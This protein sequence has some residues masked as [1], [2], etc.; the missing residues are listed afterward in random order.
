MNKKVKLTLLQNKRMRR[1]IAIVTIIVTVVAN[2]G[3]GNSWSYFGINTMQVEAA[4]KK[5]T[6]IKLN[7]SKKTL[8]EGTTVTL[9]VKK[10][11]PVKASS[12]VSW[13]TSNKRVATVTAKGKVT[14]KKVGT[15]KI[16]AVSKSNKKVK[17]VC[18]ITVKKKNTATMPPQETPVITAVTVP[19]S[20]TQMDAP[21]ET[22]QVSTPGPEATPVREIPVLGE[23]VYSGFY[24]DTTWAIDKNGLLEVKGTGDM[25][26]VN[27]E[28][29]WRKY[30]EEIRCARIEVT[31]ATNLGWMFSEC[32][33]LTNLDISKLDT[34]KVTDMSCMFSG[35]V[36][37][38]SLDLSHWDDAGVKRSA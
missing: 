25:W 26:D 32:E 2:V 15:V 14:A 8:Y 23:V 3:L 27:G 28:P 38:S 12:A 24:G 6:A 30:T 29:G 20:A 21:T 1:V 36:K 5:P 17:A 18:K 34:S 11:T 7:I 33:E 31:G 22:N 10:V 19:T 4:T 37:L 35:C 16:T 13:K 9:K